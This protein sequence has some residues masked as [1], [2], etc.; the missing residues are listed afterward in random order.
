[1]FQKRFQHAWV[2]NGTDSEDHDTTGRWMIYPETDD[3][4]ELLTF[5]R[6]DLEYDRDRL[7]KCLD[8]VERFE[9]G[10]FDPQR[11][12]PGIQASVVDSGN[13][14]SCTTG[15]GMCSSPPAM[16]TAHESS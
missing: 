10:E 6:I 2:P 8:V 5:L 9:S 1:M 3:A 13:D 11:A 12:K 16:T 4:R 15:T 7:A 14:G